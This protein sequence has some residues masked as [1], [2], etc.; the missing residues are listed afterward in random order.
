MEQRSRRAAFDTRQASQQRQY[1]LFSSTPYTDVTMTGEH[2]LAGATPCCHRNMPVEYSQI[3]TCVSN[4]AKVKVEDGERMFSQCARTVNPPRRPLQSLLSL[5]RFKIWYLIYVWVCQTSSHCKGSGIDQTWEIW[6]GTL[7]CSRCEHET[8]LNG[9]M[10]D[11]WLDHIFS[12]IVVVWDTIKLVQI[13][14]SYYCS[15]SA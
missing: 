13:T 9:Q 10:T 1:T 14:H 15:K 3:P 12:Q 5:T 2:S 11:W 4:R 7:D 8:R 6:P